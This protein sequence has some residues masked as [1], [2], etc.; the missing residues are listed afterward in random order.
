[1]HI[2]TS[3]HAF[4]ALFNYVRIYYTENKTWICFK[5]KYKINF[6]M[7]QYLYVTSNICYKNDI[8]Y[9]TISLL[10]GITVVVV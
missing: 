8:I 9:F 1:M 5:K 3:M 6:F 4:D 10:V 2:F 7:G